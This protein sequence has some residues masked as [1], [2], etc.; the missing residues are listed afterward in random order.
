[1]RLTVSHSLSGRHNEA[2]TDTRRWNWTRQGRAFVRTC[3]QSSH[4][5][6]G[7]YKTFLENT[8]HFE[9]ETGAHPQWIS[10]PWLA[11]NSLRSR[12]VIG[13]VWNIHMGFQNLF[14]ASS[15]NQDSPFCVRKSADMTLWR[16]SKLKSLKFNFWA[17]KWSPKSRPGITC[18]SFSE[19]WDVWTDA[20]SHEFGANLERC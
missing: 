18:D 13:S 2:Q 14:H 6:S 3:L 4:A 7:S 5:R 12:E 10:A 20:T 1:M 19:S 17:L 9:G 16:L 8:K 15:M 11:T